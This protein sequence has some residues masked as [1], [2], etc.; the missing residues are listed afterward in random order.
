MKG[1]GKIFGDKKKKEKA[2]I[3]FS[4]EVKILGF[5]IKILNLDLR[6]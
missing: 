4:L 6:F 1:D 3:A 2:S 5:D